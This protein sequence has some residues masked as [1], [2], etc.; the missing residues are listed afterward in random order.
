L[1]QA[2]KVP[3]RPVGKALL[4][5]P[6]RCTLRRMIK[7]ISDMLRKITLGLTALAALGLGLGIGGFLLVTPVQAQQWESSIRKFEEMDKLN[8]PKPGVIV[9]TGSSSIV[10]WG[11]LA[12]DMKPLA[13]INRAFGGSQYTDVNQFAKRIVN[14]YR[15][16]AVVVY[17]GDNDLAENSPKTP[18]SV[19]GDVR[20]FVQ[21]VRADLPDT[22]I[23]VLSIKPS[24]LRWKQWPNM[25]AAD[26]M[27]QEFLRTQQRAQYIDVATPMFDAQ[28]NL[29]EDLFV[30][31]GLHP[32]PKCYAIWTSIIKPVLLKRFGPKAN[33]SQGFEIGPWLN[34]WDG[35]PTT[36]AIRR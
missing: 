14:V 1:C 15:P 25:K 24:K 18:E 32:T 23:Y 13:I 26:Q 4:F 29:P 8:P 28:G 7:H 34:S 9:F 3:F 20:Q 11:T 10:R 36:V 17:A 6:S 21:I 19:A 27:I 31:D 16:S 22:W 30:A 33:V 12:D 5:P 35:L 2:R